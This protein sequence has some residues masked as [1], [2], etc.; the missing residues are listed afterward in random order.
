MPTIYVLSK[1]IKNIKIFLMKF[2]I[3]TSEKKKL[4]IAWACFGNVAVMFFQS[5]NIIS[6]SITLAEAFIHVIAHKP[7]DLASL[8]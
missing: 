4:Y 8:I 1:N 2:S 6:T 7:S 3:F 5:C